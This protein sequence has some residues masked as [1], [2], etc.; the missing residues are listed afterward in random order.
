MFRHDK[1]Q[2]VGR[3]GSHKLTSCN[4][5]RCPEEMPLPSNEP[6]ALRYSKTGTASE[7]IAE[8]GWSRKTKHYSIQFHTIPY[9]C[10]LFHTIP[11]YYILLHTIPYHSV[12]LR[13]ISI[14]FHTITY[15]FHT[16]SIL[17]PY[18]FHTISMKSISK[19]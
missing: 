5:W 14:P 9:H 17:F 6:G 7:D 3:S 2:M 15:Y 18:Y 11:Y 16:I 4:G 19:T 10:I 12:L 8:T 1:A 13:T